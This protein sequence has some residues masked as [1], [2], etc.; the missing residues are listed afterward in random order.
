MEK[1]LDSLLARIDAMSDEELLLEEDRLS[2]IAENSPFGGEWAAGSILLGPTG[3]ACLAIFWKLGDW[4]NRNVDLW[5]N[6]PGNPLL[7][8]AVVGWFGLA[9]GVAMW[10][11]SSIWTKDSSRA[12]R[13]AQQIHVGTVWVNCWMLRDLTMPFGGMKHSGLGREGGDFSLDF[14]TEVKTICLKI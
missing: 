11:S 14:F 13:V 9:L 6:R 2:L 10:L 1:D 8:L 5:V 7:I 12:H 4:L 3:L